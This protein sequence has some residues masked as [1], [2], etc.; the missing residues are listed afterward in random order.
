M[1]DDRCTTNCWLLH[2]YSNFPQRPTT[3]LA[4]GG[5]SMVER[6]R[7]WCSDVDG[8]MVV[9]VVVVAGAG[10]LL[11]SRKSL[12]GRWAWCGVWAGC[13]RVFFITGLGSLVLVFADDGDGDGREEGGSTV[14][15]H[16][17]IE[18]RSISSINSLQ[19]PMIPMMNRSR[20]EG[21]VRR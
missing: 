12:R 4:S 9:M 21:Q 10:M 7:W 15:Y 20:E 11:Q 19:G 18:H 14:V 8:V 2:K 5:G 6:G 1:I 3:I 16:A 13:G 17:N